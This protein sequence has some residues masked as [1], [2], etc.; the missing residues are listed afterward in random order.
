VIEKEARAAAFF[1]VA[2]ISFAGC[3]LLM[4]RA[5]FR[6]VRGFSRRYEHSGLAVGVGPVYFFFRRRRIFH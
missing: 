3:V 1:A 5:L 6:W 4:F 2:T